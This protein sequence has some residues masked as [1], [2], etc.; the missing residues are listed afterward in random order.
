[1]TYAPGLGGL[2]VR[3]D[4]RWP[5]VWL[6]WEDYLRWVEGRL[7]TTADYLGRV[8]RLGPGWDPGQHWALIGPT[9][10]GKTT[11]AV[12]VLGTR[13]FV[14]ALDPKGDDETLAGSGYVK[15]ASI[16]RDSLIWAARNRDDARTWRRIWEAIEEGRPA[17]VIVRGPAD[18]AAQLAE[19]RALIAEAFDFARFG[20]GWTVY[21]D[22]FEVATSR[23]MFGLAAAYN[24]GL[25]TA[26]H[27]AVSLLNSY[28]AQAW[29]SKH[30]IRQARRATLWQ[31]GDRDMIKNVARG[32]GRDW[33]ESAQIVDALTELDYACAT[34]CRGPRWPVVLTKPPKVA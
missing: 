34:F 31:T 12:G 8:V 24:Q 26:R 27:R 2:E 32:M 1:M 33:V 19:L 28:Q 4:G 23:E 16:W 6:D 7:A 29:V 25:I 5:V 9:G 22:E 17:R 30:A 13:R 14:M 20:H 10:E 3:R 21:C 18:S 11:F 15:V